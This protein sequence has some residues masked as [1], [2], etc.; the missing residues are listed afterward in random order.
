MTT[1]TYVV[2]D[3]ETTGLFSFKD[4]QGNPIPADADGQPRLAS[5]AAIITDAE[6]NEISREKRYVK[7]DGWSIDGTEAS[8][9]NGLTDAFLNENGVPVAEV[10]DMWE[11]FIDGGLIAVAH[12]AQFDAKMMRAELRRA[13][14][15]DL[16]EQTAQTCTM[17]SCAK[18]YKDTSMQ[19]KRGQ[20]VKLE[21]ACAFFGI[22]LEN[23][24]DAM[25]DA[26]AAAEILKR[27]IADGTLIDPKVHYAKNPPQASQEP[28]QERVE[29][30]ATVTTGT[31]LVLAEGASLV[32]L[33]KKDEDGKSKLIPMIETIENEVRA[34]VFSTA[35]KKDR[36][37]IASVAYKVSR[38]KSALDKAGEELKAEAQKVVNSVNADRKMVKD[39]L[40]ALRDETRKPLTEWE[41][42][43]KERQQKI[44]DTLALM[45]VNAL[46]A[47]MEPVDIRNRMSQVNAIDLEAP[48][49]G[50]QKAEAELAKAKCMEEWPAVLEAAEKRV[51]EVAEL[52]ELRRERVEREEREA[53][54]KA[55]A[56]EQARREQEETERKAREEA[57]ARALDDRRRERLATEFD[58]D[59]SL[60]SETPSH[61]LKRILEVKYLIPITDAEW[62]NHMELAGM[63][64]EVIVTKLEALI[65]ASEAREAEEARQKEAELEAAR[66][67]AEQ[68]RQAAAKERRDEII[69]DIAKD[70]GR[71]DGDPDLI[72]EAIFDGEIKHV[73]VEVE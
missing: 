9:V 69:A 73:Y 43:E 57:A 4:E 58:L 6:G 44:S 72:A 61:D 62:G 41:N 25:A 48:F 34:E 54:E 55:E 37:H 68:D 36:D 24:H 51:A 2:F 30:S 33:Y 67:K 20:Y 32:D 46:A 18:G 16:F 38:S 29:G 14:R 65:V 12:N 50:D 71:F 1:P 13:G 11:A 56:E 8:K 22:K 7:P 53:K 27:L 70:V 35:T 42:A 60:S 64:K 10:L 40:D 15:D 47:H 45:D 28:G 49:W 5:F 26:E 59:E 31:D 19:I 3:T 17:R 63:K 21:D 23:A 39:R 52:E 66:Q